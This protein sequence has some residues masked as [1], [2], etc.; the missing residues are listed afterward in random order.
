LP[1]FEEAGPETVE[2]ILDEA[3]KLASKQQWAAGR[4]VPD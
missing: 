2:A 3:A 4:K 1:G